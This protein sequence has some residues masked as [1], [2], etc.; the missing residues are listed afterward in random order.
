MKSDLLPLL[1]VAALAGAC[2]TAPAAPPTAEPAEEATAEAAPPAAAAPQAGHGAHHHGTAPPAAEP[3]AGTD[4]RVLCWETEERITLA[5][6]GEQAGARRVVRMRFQPDAG[7]VIVE[8][9]R[10]DPDPRVPPR[11]YTV[12]WNVEG[13]SFTLADPE[14]RMGG[15][16]TLA[17]EAWEWSGWSADSR[18]DSGIRI[19]ERA[20]IG[21][22][23]G[24]TLDR[25]AFGPDG[26]AV[27]T[28]HEEGRPLES[29]EC[30]RRIAAP[31]EA[32]GDG[33]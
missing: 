14:A 4:A 11:L 31:A 28:L 20:T 9:L 10:L 22:D 8:T 16:G 6:G 23:G 5:T 17:G 29:G 33:G 24:L 32:G 1:V 7:R 26:Q 13:D 2:G 25:E 18:L 12:T 30:A 21:A 19:A 15:S 3:V 27:M